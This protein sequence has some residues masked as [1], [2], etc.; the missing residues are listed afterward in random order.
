[1]GHLGFLMSGGPRALRCLP[2][3]Q[4][5]HCKVPAMFQQKLH[6]H[7]WSTLEITQHRSS[8]LY[9]SKQF[10]KFSGQEECQSDFRCVFKLRQFTFW[11]QL[12]KQNSFTPFPRPLRFH[13]IMVSGL[14]F[15][16]FSSK[17]NPSVII[18]WGSSSLD[19]GFWVQ[20]L[21]MCKKFSQLWNRVASFLSHI[22][23]T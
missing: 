5:P 19:V 14:K 23:N 16:I 9:W 20:S 21:S 2:Y 13:Y 22:P 18:F 6:Y 11:A 1:M 8:L 15:R 4:S 3:Q 7:L 12:S 10:L 17:S